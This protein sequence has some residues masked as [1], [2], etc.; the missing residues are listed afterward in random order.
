MKAGW[1]VVGD[2]SCH[3]VHEDTKRECLRYSVEP[4]ACDNCASPKR[5]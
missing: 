1:Q 4:C 3:Q 2:P 5:G